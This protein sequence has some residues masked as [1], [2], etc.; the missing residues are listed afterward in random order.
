MK[1]LVTGGTG[2]IGRSLVDRLLARNHSITVLSRR[3]S[4]ART[5]LPPTVFTYEWRAETGLPPLESLEGIDTVVNLAGA[6]IQGRWTRKKKL[7]ILQS[8]T[9]ASRNLS[10]A[11]TS[12]RH[13]PSRLV[14]ASAVG[15]YGDRGDELLAEDSAPGQGFLPNVV[16]EWERGWEPLIAAGSKVYPIRFGLVLSAQGGVLK[17]LLPAWRL[18]LGVKIGTGSQ[19]WPWVHIE[20]ALDLIET[21]VDGDMAS[22]PVVAAAPGEVTQA[23][24]ADALAKVLHRPRFLRVPKFAINTILGEMAFELTASR[25]ATSSLDFHSYRF[26][27]LSLALEDLV[28]TRERKKKPAHRYQTETEVNAPVDEVFKFFSNPDNL[29]TLTP[30]WLHFK[31]VTQQPLE[32]KTGT[33]IDY[34][35]R[36]HRVPVS[37]QSKITEWRPPFRFIDIQTKGPYRSWSHIHEFEELSGR[38][39]VRDTI[40]YEVPGGFIVDR[41]LVR[42]DIERIFNYRQN[43]L[44]EF[45]N[46]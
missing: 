32:I 44:H 1:I 46:Q 43:K 5:I 36:I 20:D 29:E 31:M 10:E 25:R 45:F 24:F 28:S 17:N 39:L 12:L 21:L 13:P 9:V 4:H 2:L 3:P 30:P 41:L 35:L 7:N 18:G 16:Q 34:R 37:W 42:N 6:P 8:R 15:Y 22:G 14:S 26:P 40:D 33:T 38:T 11:L 19:W 23:Q 27:E